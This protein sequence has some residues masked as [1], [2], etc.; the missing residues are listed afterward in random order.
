M[1]KDDTKRPK[2]KW[3]VSGCFLTTFSNL[4]DIFRRV[5]HRQAFKI[6]RYGLLFK[7]E[8][9]SSLWGLMLSNFQLVHVAVDNLKV[10]CRF[11][12]ISGIKS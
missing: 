9:T 6:T 1:K 10:H 8:F 12:F 4:N 5:N 11:L 3:S 2:S 7:T